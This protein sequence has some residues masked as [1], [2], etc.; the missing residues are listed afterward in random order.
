MFPQETLQMEE[1]GSKEHCYTLT[2]LNEYTNTIRSI[3]HDSLLDHGYFY[4]GFSV[5]AHF[6]LLY[7][8]VKVTKTALGCLLV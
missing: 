7:A 1:V 2:S 4:L 3:M 8:G 6:F 5:H